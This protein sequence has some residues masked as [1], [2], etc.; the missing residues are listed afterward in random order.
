MKAERILN[1]ITGGGVTGCATCMAVQRC[2][3]VPVGFTHAGQAAITV[4]VLMLESIKWHRPLLLMP[5]E[6]Y[7]SALVFQGRAMISGGT[8]VS[9]L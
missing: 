1:R 4:S 2:S 5:Y 6:C 9:A 3:K 8:F 7:G